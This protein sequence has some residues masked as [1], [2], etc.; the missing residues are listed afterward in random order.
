MLDRQ[1]VR[2]CR[3][4]RILGRHDLPVLPPERRVRQLAPTSSIRKSGRS[5]GTAS[6]RV[7]F[8]PFLQQ[9]RPARDDL[10]LYRDLIDAYDRWFRHRQRHGGH[11]RSSSSSRTTAA[12]TRPE[13]RATS[14]E[15]A[16]QGRGGRRRGCTIRAEIPFEG[17]E[18]IPSKERARRQ[19]F[20][21]AGMGVDPNPENFGNSSGVALW[22][23]Y[24]LLSS[25]RDAGNAVRSVLLSWYAPSAVWRVSRAARAYFGMT[26]GH[27][28]WFRT[29]SKPRRSRSS[30][31]SALSRQN[32][33]CKPSVG[34]RCRERAV[35]AE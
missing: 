11:R 24:S 7:P 34:R 2:P 30:S 26:H 8:I 15:Q 25:G 4:V 22:H 21:K 29:A 18:R 28:T 3:C 16:H 14:K 27:A 13:L 5:C 33:S 19:I 23:L 6:A 32:D 20:V 1:A 35:A 31:R 17:A 9:R 12:R 10:P